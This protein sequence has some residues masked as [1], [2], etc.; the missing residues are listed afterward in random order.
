MVKDAYK[1]LMKFLSKGL[2][3]SFGDYILSSGIKSPY[4]IDF[5]YL[6]SRPDYLR[7]VI[8][9]F[10][11][12][13]V[14]KGISRRVDVIAG[15]SNK[16]ILFLPEL[17]IRLGKPFIYIDKVSME[18]VVGYLGT[19][20]RVLIIDDLINT[21]RTLTNVI[22]I[23][24]GRYNAKVEYVVVF[25]DR[26]EGG[27]RKIRDLGVKIY[28]LVKISKLAREM[29]KVGIITDE[30]YNIIIKRVKGGKLGSKY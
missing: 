10:E 15:I 29:R 13:I 3:L 21:G 22:S 17:S 18:M 5:S 14:N 24:R 26:E 6:A 4:Y 30:E 20:E 1:L 9:L 7:E 16:G 23:L 25:L 8:R 2:V 11:S 12:F 19:E 27:A 28:S